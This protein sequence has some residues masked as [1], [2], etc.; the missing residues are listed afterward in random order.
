MAAALGVTGRAWGQLTL[1]GFSK[2]PDSDPWQFVDAVALSP[3]ALTEKLVLGSR[4]CQWNTEAVVMGL[5][6]KR[7]DPAEVLVGLTQKLLADP[8]TDDKDKRDLLV[9][10]IGALA[11]E[12]AH[13]AGK[14]APRGIEALLNG[15]HY[16]H[17]WRVERV[18]AFAS[19]IPAPRLRAF[20]EAQMDDFSFQL[21]EYGKKSGYGHLSAGLLRVA[22]DED[23]ARRWVAKTCE[24]LASSN[25]VLR[26]EAISLGQAGPAVLP[27]VLEELAKRPRGDDAVSKP[28]DGLRLAVAVIAAE[29]ARTGQPI[30]PELDPHFSADDELR[31]SENGFLDAKVMGHI[32]EKLPAHRGARVVKSWLALESAWVNKT[33]PKVAPPHLRSLVVEETLAERVV[34]LASAT[35][36]ACDTRIYALLPVPSEIDDDDDIERLAGIVNRAGAVPEALSADRIPKVKN[37][38]MKHVITFDLD[39]MPEVKSRFNAKGARAMALFVSPQKSN[40][41]GEPFNDDMVYVPLSEAEALGGPKGGG[42]RAFTIVPLDVPGAAFTNADGPG[43]ADMR[44]AIVGLPGRALGKPNLIQDGGEEALE[45][46]AAEFVMQLDEGIVPM[47]LGDQGLVYLYQITAFWQCH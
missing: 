16:E 40:G 20:L 2:S 25:E 7:D 46:M 1:P 41:S 32:L 27:L 35:G 42:G 43:L 17:A 31:Q 47:N 44:R 26:R 6:R 10:A 36:L 13:G 21:V 23:L 28:R 34:R 11:L 30:P 18:V 15:R 5:L 45:H 22:Y 29:L 19:A 3:F 8:R 38:P 9:E 4:P 14:E 33:L 37:K 12:R 24:S 39:A